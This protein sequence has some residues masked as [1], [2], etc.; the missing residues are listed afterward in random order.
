MELLAFTLLRP[1]FRLIYEP[2]SLLPVEKCVCLCLDFRVLAQLF[3]SKRQ[4]SLTSNFLLWP[5]ALWKADYTKVKRT[6]GMDAYFF[7]RF[8]RMLIR[9]FLPIWFL[10]WVVLLPVTS[11]NTQVGNNDGLNKLTVCLR[12][13]LQTVSDIMHSLVTWKVPKRLDTRHTW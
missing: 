2:R 4:D 12:S 10:T 13:V 6:N 8:L 5:L 7:L 1:Q 11:V 3:G 9:M